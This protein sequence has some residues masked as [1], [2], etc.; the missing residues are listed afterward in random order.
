[1]IRNK[2][3]KVSKLAVHKMNEQEENEDPEKQKSENIY[4]IL[5]S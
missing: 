4:I 5:F 3:I 2:E 1:M